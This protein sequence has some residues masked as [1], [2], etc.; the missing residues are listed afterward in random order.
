M[1]GA[2]LFVTA[3]ASRLLPI[4]RRAGQRHKPRLVEKLHQPRD[5][6]VAAQGPPGAGATGTTGSAG[7]ISPPATTRTFVLDQQ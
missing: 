1:V 4:P 5:L 2:K 6:S 3:P 7:P